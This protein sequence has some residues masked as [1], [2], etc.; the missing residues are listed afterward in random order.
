MDHLDFK[1]F[2][3]ERMKERGLTIRRLA[4][5]SGVTAENLLS[6]SEERFAD[7]PAAPYLRGYLAKIGRVLDFDPAP[8]WE[9]FERLKAF[10]SSGPADELPQNRF[11]QK[12]VAKYGWLVLLGII[13]LAYFGFQFRHIFGKPTIAVSYPPEGIVRVAQSAA[14]V[15]GNVEGSTNLS[16]NNEPIPVGTDGTWGKNIVLQ[17]GMNTIEIRA[18]KFLGGETKVVRQILYEPP[19][20]AASSTPAGTPP[21][22]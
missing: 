18:S 12:P 16:I 7:L 6:L 13:F 8:W 22:L 3:Y 21:A 10:R 20:K 1:T 5:L 14:R 4:E 19:A 17:L 15:M 2:F 11:T 9:Y